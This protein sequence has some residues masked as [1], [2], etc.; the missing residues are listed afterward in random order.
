MII[1]RNYEEIIRL[2]ENLVHPISEE[3]LYVVE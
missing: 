2:R 3:G 1:A